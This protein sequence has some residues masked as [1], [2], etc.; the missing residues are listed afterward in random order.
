M[1][2]HL[3]ARTPTHSVSR[4]DNQQPLTPMVSF[5]CG[6]F[7]GRRRSFSRDRF[8]IP[9]YHMVQDKTKGFESLD[10]PPNQFVKVKHHLSVANEAVV[11][12][13]GAV[14]PQEGEIGSDSTL[15][16]PLFSRTP[17]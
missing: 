2:A 8:E 12:R 17:T 3:F 1:I 13:C 16:P 10:S 7:L 11:A 4:R 9:L 6:V 14:P 15:E 5:E